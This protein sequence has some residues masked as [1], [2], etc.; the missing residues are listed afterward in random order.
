MNMYDVLVILIN[1]LANTSFSLI[2]RIKV[3]TDLYFL[4]ASDNCLVKSNVTLP[5][6]LVRRGFVSVKSSGLADV[7]TL[8]GR[9]ALV[10]GVAVL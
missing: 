5:P 9:E 2:I 4:S 10:G 3:T 6:G 1:E 7:C 8:I